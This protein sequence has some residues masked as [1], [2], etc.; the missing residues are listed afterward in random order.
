MVSFG[1][2]VCFASQA[3]RTNFYGLACPFYCSQPGLG[4]LL[5]SFLAGLGLGFALAAYLAWSLFC[6][7]HLSRGSVPGSSEGSSPSS[8][9][10]ATAPEKQKRMENQLNECAYLISQLPAL[11]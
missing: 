4:A 10:D 8:L 9:P 3:A 5:S 11:P 1:D 6:F 2:L 7:W